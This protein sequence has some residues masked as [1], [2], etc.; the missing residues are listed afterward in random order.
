MLPASSLGG[1]AGSFREK[2]IIRVGSGILSVCMGA[3]TPTLTGG[4]KI[5]FSE[6]IETG[7]R[8]E[9]LLGLPSWDYAKRILKYNEK[10]WERDMN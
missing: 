10:V 7:N 8:D 2:I 4:L 3:P 9:V 1:Q 5:K 6:T